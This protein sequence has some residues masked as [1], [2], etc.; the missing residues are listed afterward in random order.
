MEPSAGASARASSIG[1]LPQAL[2]G[3][4]FVLAGSAKQLGPAVTLLS[5]AWRDTFYSEP[6]FWSRVYLNLWDLGQCSDSHKAAWLAVKTALLRRVAPVLSD[7]RLDGIDR[8]GGLSISGVF[9]HIH[10][11][12]LEVLSLGCWAA[13]PPGLLVPFTGLR[14]LELYRCSCDD[15]GNWEPAVLEAVCSMRQL[16][17]LVIDA[18][19]PPPQVLAIAAQLPQLRHLQ[20][21]SSQLL[22]HAE[23]LAVLTGLTSL[24]LTEHAAAGCLQ[25]P[26]LAHFPRL[27][28]YMLKRG[29][30]P[31]EPGMM[32][33]PAQPQC[34][35]PCCPRR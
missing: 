9:D 18:K 2:L 3:K 13:L 4:I 7:L 27:S 33:A 14:S 20:V 26:D 15:E 5:H 11:A 21:V 23:Q 16:T 1:D 6:A 32:R 35:V 22:P 10:P 31:F 25:P 19:S 12:T 24:V 30:M 34:Y 29:Q 28:S 8:A 17:G